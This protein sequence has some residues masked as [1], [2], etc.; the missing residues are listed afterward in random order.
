MHG[1]QMQHEPP[2]SKEYRYLKLLLGGV[3][4][5]AVGFSMMYFVYGPKGILYLVGGLIAYLCGLLFLKV[6]RT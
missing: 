2:A 1:L 4:G 6:F 3:I 5:A